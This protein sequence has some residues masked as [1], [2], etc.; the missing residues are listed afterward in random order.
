MENNDHN[1]QIKLEENGNETFIFPATLVEN[2]SVAE[3]KSAKEEIDR[4]REWLGMK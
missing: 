3:D 2:V 4:L 1:I